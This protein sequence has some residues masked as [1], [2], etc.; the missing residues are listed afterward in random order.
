MMSTTGQTLASL[1]ECPICLG[2]FKDPRM[3]TCLHTLCCT[4]LSDHINHSGSN[5]QFLCPVCRRSVHIPK[6]GAEEFPKNFFINSYMDIVVDAGTGAKSKIVSTDG[7][8]EPEENNCSNYKVG[9]DCTQPE[10]FCIECCE[11]YCKACSATHCKFK[12]YRGHAMVNMC[13]LTKEI[14]RDAMVKSKAPR[15]VAQ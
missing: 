7:R 1:M 12:A 13:D 3:L 14:W 4:C 5:G 9:E 15:C 8:H 10:Q 2:P 6:D 11:Y